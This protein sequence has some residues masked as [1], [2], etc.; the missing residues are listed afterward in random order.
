MKNTNSVMKSVFEKIRKERSLFIVLLVCVLL[1]STF[2]L[3]GNSII[4]ASNERSEVESLSLALTESESI[5]EAESLSLAEVSEKLTEEPPTEP[6]TVPEETTEGILGTAENPILEDIDIKN[7]DSF[8]FGN[9]NIILPCTLKEL[10]GEDKAKNYEEKLEEL[11]NGEK[12]TAYYELTVMADEQL[13]KASCELRIAEGEGTPISRVYINSIMTTEP[14]IVVNG[15]T[16]GNTLDELISAMDENTKYSPVGAV[17]PP[18]VI[19][20]SVHYRVAFQINDDNK[21]MDIRIS[22]VGNDT[23]TI[24]VP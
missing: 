20:R 6:T 10:I 7:I 24:I 2:V 19:Y 4:K 12:D 16:V 11:I 3:F 9:H 23:E 18:I 1:L 21:I 13:H 22:Y 15:I 17:T 14:V 8:V 5:S